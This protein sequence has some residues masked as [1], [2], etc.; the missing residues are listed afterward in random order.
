MFKTFRNILIINSY[1][2]I[3]NKKHIQYEPVD[4]TNVNGHCFKIFLPLN[5][6]KD[7]AYEAYV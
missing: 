3:N 4:L 6:T 5:R 1:A 2:K 7:N